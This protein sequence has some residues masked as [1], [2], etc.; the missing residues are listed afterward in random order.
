M[1]FRVRQLP[2]NL[3]FFALGFVYL[4]LVVE[5]DLL[6]HCFGTILPAAP[7]FATGKAFLLDRSGTPGG[8]ILYAAGLLSQGYYS[9]WL[10]AAIIVLAALGLAELFRRHLALVGVTRSAWLTSLPA[11]AIFLIY[12]R[13]KHPLAICLTIALGLALSL[14]FERLALRRTMTRVA[15][16]CLIA[17]FGFWMGGSGTLMVFAILTAI[18]ALFLRKDWTLAILVLPASVAIVWVL[19]QYVF[20]ITP[21]RAFVVLSPFDASL[22]AGMDR[23]ET[24]LVLLLYGLA[25][26]AALLGLV[27]TRTLAH[28]RHSPKATRPAKKHSAKERRRPVLALLKGPAWTALPIVLMALGLYWGHDERRKPYVLSNYYSCRRQWDEILE[29]GHRLP[30]GMTNVFVNHDILR[31]LYHKG[32]LP[33]DM[34]EFPLNPHALM[35]THEEKESDL[36]LSKLSDLFLELGHVNMAQKLASELLATKDYFGVALER[37]AWINT[38]KDLPATA[39]VY[40]SALQ[41]DVIRRR[42]ADALLHNLEHGF[43]ADQAAFID[44]VRSC[45]LNDPLAV[46]GREPVDQTLATLLEGN[47]HNKMAF[48]YL[49]ACYL[50]TGKLDKIMENV[51]RLGDL[52]YRQIPPL[53]EEA[54]LIHYASQRQKPDLGRIKISPETIQRYQRFVQIRSGL[55]PQN[56]QETLKILIREFG[57][58]YFFY[59][60]F[61]Q[62][63][64]V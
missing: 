53:Y 18:H 56:Q 57:A 63:G 27:R 51:G 54:I 9:P 46:F 12:S 10:G 36:S 24:V 19:V 35:L 29:L 5:P 14:A 6:Y 16:Y 25:P 1:T 39:R 62:V 30:R 11:V 33:Y 64:Q 32:R 7:L 38:V 55:Q 31:A 28:A 15:G 4:W 26:L 59:F 41:R 43:P 40:A 45:T 8:G 47:P 50:L 22:T 3:L 13:Y 48:E 20:L 49:M 21:G 37:L 17:A 44:R 42:T 60:A 34:F 52:G 23:F 58:S 61:G 2:H